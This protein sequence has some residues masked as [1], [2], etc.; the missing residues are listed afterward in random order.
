[1]ADEKIQIDAGAYD[2]TIASTGD[3]YLH[4]E[5]NLATMEGKVVKLTIISGDPV[6]FN[7]IGPASESN[8]EYDVAEFVYLTLLPGNDLSFNGEISTVFRFEV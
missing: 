5:P 1:M 6:K 3:N 8:V 2:I 4:F 7:N